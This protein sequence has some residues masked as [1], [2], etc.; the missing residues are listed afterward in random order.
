[1]FHLHVSFWQWHCPRKRHRGWSNSKEIHHLDRGCLR[2]K[3]GRHASWRPPRRK[4][5]VAKRDGLGTGIWNLHS[6]GL[7][8]KNTPNNTTCKKMVVCS[9]GHIQLPLDWRCRRSCRSSWAATMGVSRPLQL[10]Q[11]VG[12]CPCCFKEWTLAVT[13]GQMQDCWKH[14]DMWGAART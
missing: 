2:K 7:N 10:H 11:G 12:M 4:K 13:I 9:L 3:A 6:W 5:F 1:M 14:V 8:W